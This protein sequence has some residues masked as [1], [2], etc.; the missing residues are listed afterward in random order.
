M[1]KAL[2]RERLSV[3]LSEGWKRTPR[4]SSQGSAS[5][6]ER[7]VSRARLSSVSPP[8]T[9]SRSSQYSSSE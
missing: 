5:V 7:I 4:D 8:V 9:R 6:V 1:K 3:P 2:V